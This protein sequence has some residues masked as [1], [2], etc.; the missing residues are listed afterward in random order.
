MTFQDGL[1]RIYDLRKKSPVNVFATRQNGSQV[2]KYSPES[3]MIVS[4]GESDVK[5]FNLNASG[6]CTKELITNSQVLFYSFW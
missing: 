4:G 2:L 6:F 5:I 3:E 1:I